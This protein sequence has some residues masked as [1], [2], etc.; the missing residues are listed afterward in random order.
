MASNEDHL[1]PPWPPL[2][3]FPESR[4]GSIRAVDPDF[5][6]TAGGREAGKFRPSAEPMLDTVAVANDDGTPIGFGERSLA[7]E[8][9]MLLKAIL[10][11]I[12]LM[13]DMSVDALVEAGEASA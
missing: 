8:Q 9:V 12:S 5:P 3:P 2:H 6:A 11:G 13:V 7:E 1:P 4:R 10:F